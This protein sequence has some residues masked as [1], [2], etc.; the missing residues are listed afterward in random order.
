MRRALQLARF[1]VALGVLAIVLAV[2]SIA[3]AIDAA[4]DDS[5]PHWGWVRCTP[6]EITLGTISTNVC[7]GNSGTF[8]VN[9]RAVG[10]WNGPT[11]V[12]CF[13][14]DT[15]TL[16]LPDSSKILFDT[17]GSQINNAQALCGGVQ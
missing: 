11:D 17:T 15:R 13:A 10:R 3:L 2:A 16:L 1:A 6:F 5:P 7:V 14:I 12:Q 4:N 9:G 8:W